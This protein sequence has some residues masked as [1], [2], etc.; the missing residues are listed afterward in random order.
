[1]SFA[2]NGIAIVNGITNIKEKQESKTTLFHEDVEKVL[3]L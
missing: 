1:M 2:D 3:R